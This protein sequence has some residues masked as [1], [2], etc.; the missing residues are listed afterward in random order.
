[1]KYRMML[2]GFGL[3]ILLSPAQSAWAGN[4]AHGGDVVFCQGKE[5]VVLDYYQ[6]AL[7]TVGGKKRRLVDMT[8]WSE[9]KT[10]EWVDT[11]LAQFSGFHE[12]LQNYVK[13]I[14]SIEDWTDT[15]LNDSGDSGEP[16]PLP[17]D[18]YK[19]RAAARQ[20]N[21]IFG[22]GA[23]IGAI[24]P[25]QRALLL[26]HERLYALLEY[27]YDRLKAIKPSSQ[28]LTSVPVRRFIANLLDQ[29]VTRPQLMI[30]VMVFM[31]DTASFYAEPFKLYASPDALANYATF[32]SA[33]G[34][35]LCGKMIYRNEALIKG[36]NELMAVGTDLVKQLE[37]SD[38]FGSGAFKMIT[39]GYPGSERHL[40]NILNRVL[41]LPEGA[42]VYDV[43]GSTM[44]STGNAHKDAPAAA[45]REL[46]NYFA[47]WNPSIWR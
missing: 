37:V 13:F 9:K 21:M 17:K 8:G 2:A 33:I 5:P 32:G 38:Q 43:Y 28:P 23:V 36:L 29:D 40:E 41:P 42:L 1:M 22:D 34:K 10:L 35:V 27:N 47:V 12:I 14:G 44:G 4:S 15:S 26:V 7:P 6:A 3:T 30:E 11:R 45:V 31:T 46:C 18:C 16:Y 20:D 19:K 24:S 39:S 25:A